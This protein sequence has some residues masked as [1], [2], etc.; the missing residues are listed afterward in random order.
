MNMKTNATHK[1][2]SQVFD[3]WQLKQDVFGHHETTTSVNAERMQEYYAKLCADYHGYPGALAQVEA[4]ILWYK[5]NQPMN[6][7]DFVQFLEKNSFCTRAVYQEELTWSIHKI[8]KKYNALMRLLCAGVSKERQKKFLYTMAHHFFYFCF[9]PEHGAVDRLVAT[10]KLQPLIRM[11]YAVMWAQLGARGWQSWNQNLLLDLKKQAEL[12]S[13]VVYI[14]GGSTQDTYYSRGWKFLVQGTLGDTFTWSDG[15]ENLLFTRTMYQ[16]EGFFTASVSGGRKRRIPRATI[17]WDI[18]H[19]DGRPAGQLTI[20]RRFTTQDDFAYAPNRAVLISFN[21][22]YFIATAHDGG[23][24][25]DITKLDKRFQLY[26]KQLQHP[27]GKKMLERVQQL[28]AD[29]EFIQLGNCID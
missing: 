12:G 23:W 11:L 25:I 20:E 28:D 18:A 13:E 9:G 6:V 21:E 24:G 14:A 19:A 1:Q 15:K 4:M 22:L 26:V 16:E 27:L 3:S 7:G 5:K 8:I 10:E 17:V 29:F 2:T